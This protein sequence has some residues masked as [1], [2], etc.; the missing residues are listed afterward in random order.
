MAVKL[1]LALVAVTLAAVTYW[2]VGW[3]FLSVLFVLL[4]L[5]AILSRYDNF[6]DFL[7]DLYDTL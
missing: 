1:A 4:I 6:K 3:P 7:Q 5:L 2:L